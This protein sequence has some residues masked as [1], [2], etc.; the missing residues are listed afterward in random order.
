M[1]NKFYCDKCDKTFNLKTDLQR[2]YKTKLHLEGKKTYCCIDCNKTFIKQSHLTQHLNTAKHKLKVGLDIVKITLIHNK[3]YDMNII[4]SL[5]QTQKD[6]K[7]SISS[8]I[9]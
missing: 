4:K 1:T 7:I 8:H 2:H 5:R 3:K 9:I 6:L